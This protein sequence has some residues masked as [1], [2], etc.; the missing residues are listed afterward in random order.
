MVYRL[1]CSSRGEAVHYVGRSDLGLEGRISAHVRENGNIA[2]CNHNCTHVE[3]WIISFMSFSEMIKSLLRYIKK[4]VEQDRLSHAYLFTGPDRVGKTTVAIDLACLIN[5]EHKTTKSGNV[6][7]D[8]KNDRQAIRIRKG[9]HSDVKIIN[10][11]CI[12]ND[13]LSISDI[14]P[15]VALDL[16]ASIIY[17]I[18]LESPFEASFKLAKDFL[19]ASIFLFCLKAFNLFICL[20]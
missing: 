13:F 9:F 4:S 18:K 2:G 15:K 12:P 16:I 7:I 19:T 14:S 1:Y 3:F 20:F 6:I 10:Y 8:L 11:E 17:G 5:A